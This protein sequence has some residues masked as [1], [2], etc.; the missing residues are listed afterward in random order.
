MP[1]EILFMKYDLGST[2]NNHRRLIKEELDQQPDDC[3]LAT[4]IDELISYFQNKHGLAIILLGEPEVTSK[5]TK[6]SVGRYG[7]RSRYNR[8]EAVQVDAESYTLNVP[9]EGDA[10]LFFHR[11]ST[12][13]SM[14]PRGT[15][16]GQV[17]S[18]TIT[19]RSFT[20]DQ[21]N[22]AFDRFIN[23]LN[24]YLGWLA[25]TILQFNNSISSTVKQIVEMR[26][27][28]AKNADNVQ[29]GLKFK[30]QSREQAPPLN[31]PVQRKKISA[32]NFP[33]P[34][35]ETKSEPHLSNAKYEEIL[36]VLRDMSVVLERNPA[37]FSE[38]DEETLRFQF[39][40]SLNGQF[41]TDARAE[42]FNHKGKTDILITENGKN[43]FIAECKFWRGENS[44]RETVD[45][46]LSYLS[47]RDTKAAI[48]LFNRSK[49]FSQVLNL[50]PNVVARH[51]QYVKSLSGSQSETEFRYLF[52]R[53]DDAQRHV[54][55]TV[56]AYDVP[57]LGLCDAT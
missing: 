47:W 15:V 55:I 27:A 4:D 5:R 24:R 6:M 43:V 23:D 22:S 41:E 32:P 18:H 8:S 21:I 20:A 38:M 13:D 19:D 42:V 33:M 37:A 11:G 45:Q 17:I 39:L 9:F 14:P 46:L 48:I 36:H 49:N 35:L 16:C 57:T 12:W 51:D 25:P 34:S 30:L 54:Y 52:R 31:M 3:L 53:N 26:R 40:L 56:L 1:D 44:F 2:I 10:D 50:I 28:R 29:A 7:E